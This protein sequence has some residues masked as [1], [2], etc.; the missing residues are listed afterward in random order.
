[1]GFRSS[2]QSRPD[3]QRIALPERQS[4]LHR[5]AKGMLDLEL[6][7]P[8]GLPSIG[9][10][11]ILGDLECGVGRDNVGWMYSGMAMRLCYD[12]GLHLDTRQ[13]GLSEREMDIR[14]MTLWACVIY[15]RYWSLF[16]GRP[17]T[18]KSVDLEVYSLSDQFERLGTCMPAGPSRSINT[19]IYEALIDLM[20][21]AGHI[22]E[23]LEFRQNNASDRTPDQAA[24]FRMARLDKDL[25]SWMTR[26]PADL[27]YSEENRRNAPISFYLLHQ[28]YNAALILLHRPFARYDSTDDTDTQGVDLLDLHFSRASRAIC[29]KS[30]MLTILNPS[31]R[32]LTIMYCLAI[33][34]ARIFWEHRRK[35]D[36]K[37]IFSIAMQHAG[38]AA[39]ALI[40]ALAYLPDAAT[41]NSNML[42]LEVLHAALQDM[43]YSLQVAERMVTVLNAVM[44]E[45]RGGP[46]SGNNSNT[47]SRR[48]SVPIE[49]ERSL[50]KRRQ[51][52][53]ASQPTSMP[54]P[55]TTPRQDQTSI[56]S[57]DYRT[58]ALPQQQTNTGEFMIAHPQSE[59]PFWPHS[60][61]NGQYQSTVPPPALANMKPPDGQLAWSTPH[62]ASNEFSH[63]QPLPMA[64]G[65]PDTDLANLDYMQLPSQED[66][67]RWQSVYAASNTMLGPAAD[68]FPPHTSSSD[69][70]GLHGLPLQ[71]QYD[72]NNFKA[73]G[74]GGGAM[75][76]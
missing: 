22:V 31:Y 16:L 6:E 47:H 28:Q 10:L 13:I 38:V 72:P 1:M 53:H 5:E 73:S 25:Q 35:F 58:G 32:M 17:L 55:T 11:L 61:T 36:G 27:Q 12:I 7:R 45:L 46:I 68:T 19:R 4:T 39:M 65:F 23:Q 3:M 59:P 63:L 43:S 8:G 67:H 2:D 70:N 74:M 30:G 60:Y 50:G 37:V 29:T 26:L 9:A 66:W 64:S 24:Y 40:A 51:F 33:A 62:M 49:T 14:R 71:E 52:T 75:N 15:D 57:N 54:P 41:R 44:I 56:N 42:Y 20:E 18:M 69:A 21:V 76:R 34:I 48:A